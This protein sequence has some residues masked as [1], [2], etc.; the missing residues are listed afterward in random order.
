MTRGKER[1]KAN[2]PACGHDARAALG[3]ERLNLEVREGQ[4][5]YVLRRFTVD[6]I[7]MHERACKNC[8]GTFE[9]LASSRREFGDKPCKADN[10]K[11]RQSRGLYVIDALLEWRATRTP[12]ALSELCRRGGFMLDQDKAAGRPSW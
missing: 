3:V 5:A 10:L 7:A 6:G 2:R 4:P 9:C 1:K 11:R 12:E 8:G